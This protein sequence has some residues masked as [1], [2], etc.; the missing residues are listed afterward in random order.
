MT[1]PKQWVKE[2][3]KRTCKFPVPKTHIF[4]FL[5]FKTQI[6]MMKKNTKE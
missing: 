2:H 6:E 1:E 3:P 4:Y 5:F